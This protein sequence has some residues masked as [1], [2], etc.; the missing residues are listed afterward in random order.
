MMSEIIDDIEIMNFVYETINSRI[1][2]QSQDAYDRKYT[3]FDDYVSMVNELCS[4]DRLFGAGK[5]PSSK[6]R[7]SII[8]KTILLYSN[9]RKNTTLDKH[10]VRL[11]IS[12]IVASGE[13]GLKV[14]D[15]VFTIVFNDIPSSKPIVIYSLCD[16]QEHEVK[17]V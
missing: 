7:L 11:N 2:N 10:S 17:T 14:V 13:G 1:I 15:S 5:T 16:L 6:P 4:L 9:T 12:D 3:D 8:A